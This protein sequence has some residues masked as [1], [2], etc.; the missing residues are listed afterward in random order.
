[1]LPDGSAKEIGSESD[2]RAVTKCDA[3]ITKAK[4]TWE[5]QRLEKRQKSVE[6]DI[7]SS[8][9][10]AELHEYND[11]VLEGIYQ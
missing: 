11:Y 8:Q 2:L 7:G 6:D 9:D 3:S 1:M 10:P 5:Q 4:R